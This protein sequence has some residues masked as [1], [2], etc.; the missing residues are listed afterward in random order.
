[1]TKPPVPIAPS[2]GPLTREEALARLR[3]ASGRPER[4]T[5]Y[6]MCSVMAKGYSVTFERTDPREKFKVA[7]VERLD[8]FAP[9]ASSK[10]SGS[11]AAQAFNV[12]EFEADWKACPWCGTRGTIHGHECAILCGGAVRRRPD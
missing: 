10:P 5:F 4:R 3:T 1:M 8:E 12:E 6:C 9:A 7:K 2:R 11:G